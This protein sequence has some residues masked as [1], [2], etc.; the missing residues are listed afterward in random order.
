[1]RRNITVQKCLQAAFFG[2]FKKREEQPTEPVG[3]CFFNLK[4]KLQQEKS[5]YYKGRL[6][7]KWTKVF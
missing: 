1:M 2:I 6:V 4:L 3:Y 7:S 5:P